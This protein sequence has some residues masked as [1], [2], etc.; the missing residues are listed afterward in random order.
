[1]GFNLMN[2]FFPPKTKL[3]ERLSEGDLIRLTYN[4]GTQPEYTGTVEENVGGQI[5]VLTDVGYRRF[6]KAKIETV[7]KLN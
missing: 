3:I 7:R 6:N 2:V 5:L 4:G 1:M